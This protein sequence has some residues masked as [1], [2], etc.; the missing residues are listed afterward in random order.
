MNLGRH[1]FRHI[2]IYTHINTWIR[3]QQCGQRNER[4][5]MMTIYNGLSLHHT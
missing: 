4:S 3:K 1:L 5:G 2:N